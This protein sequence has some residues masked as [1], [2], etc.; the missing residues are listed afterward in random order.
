MSVQKR[1]HF[2]EGTAPV[3]FTKS[4]WGFSANAMKIVV[5]SGTLEISW[6][7]TTSDGKIKQADGPFDLEGKQASRVWLKGGSDYRLFAWVRY[8]T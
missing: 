5:D 7:G 3:N 8:N 2:E 4:E 6:D 1:W